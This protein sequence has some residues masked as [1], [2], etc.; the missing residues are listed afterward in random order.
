MQL[1]RHAEMEAWRWRYSSSGRK[2]LRSLAKPLEDGQLA[3]LNNSRCLASTLYTI[4]HS[5]IPTNKASPTKIRRA[6]ATWSLGLPKKRE[7]INFGLFLGRYVWYYFSAHWKRYDPISFLRFVISTEYIC[8]IQT[9]VANALPVIAHDLQGQQFAWVGTS[10]ALAG[11]AF[12][13]MS[14][15]FAEVRS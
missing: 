5:W 13:P 12:I 14:G 1:P 11:V 3:T 15:G 4:L 8:Y 2:V 10:Y 6:K 7:V 9:A